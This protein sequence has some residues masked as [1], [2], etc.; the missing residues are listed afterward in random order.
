MSVF[1]PPALSARLSPGGRQADYEFGS[2]CQVAAEAGVPLLT[3]AGTAAWG[4]LAGCPEAAVLNAANAARAAAE[5]VRTRRGEPQ[6]VY[7]P[8]VHCWEW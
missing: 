2:P 1:S 6:S 5:L 7:R 8:W 4:S 3:A